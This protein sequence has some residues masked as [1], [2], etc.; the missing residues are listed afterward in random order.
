MTNPALD[1]LWSAY[2]AKNP[3]TIDAFHDLRMIGALESLDGE[4]FFIN[5][6]VDGYYTTSY[7]T[8]FSVRVFAQGE[9]FRVEGD[10]QPG[11]GVKMKTLTDAQRRI[12]ELMWKNVGRVVPLTIIG[13]LLGASEADMP[14]LQYVV[15]ETMKIVR[16]KFKTPRVHF[17]TTINVG[18]TLTFVD[19]SPV[20]V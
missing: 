11:S 7:W 14:H 9:E 17:S 13:N 10:M 15:R 3:H 8:L 18:V 2:F 6:G 12:V 19:T 5:M 16:L 4:L 20:E 1:A